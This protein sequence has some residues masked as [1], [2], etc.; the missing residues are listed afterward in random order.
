M[1]KLKVKAEHGRLNLDTACINFK[2]ELLRQR[3]ML[4]GEGNAG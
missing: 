1:E 3:L 4:L 2:A